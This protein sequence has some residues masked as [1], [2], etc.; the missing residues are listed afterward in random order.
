MRQSQAA[1]WH[2]AI[3]SCLVQVRHGESLSIQTG[4]QPNFSKQQQLKHA[5]RGL[6]QFTGLSGHDAH[7]GRI[8]VKQFG[9]RIFARQ[10]AQQQFIQVVPG[11]QRI[12]RWHHMATDPFHG[13]QGSNVGIATKGNLNGLKRQ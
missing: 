6:Q 5:K 4:Q 10:K 7:G 8:G 3:V 1:F 2:Q 12:T 9:M 11:K 13:L